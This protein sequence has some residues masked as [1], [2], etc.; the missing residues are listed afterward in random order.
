MR[1]GAKGVLRVSGRVRKNV[2][3]GVMTV[4]GEDEVR[5]PGIGGES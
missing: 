3:G 4:K 2:E 1:Q 5:E